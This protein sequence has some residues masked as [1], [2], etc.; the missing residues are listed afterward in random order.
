MT[1][2]RSAPLRLA[3]SPGRLRLA[4]ACALA[5]HWGAL[6][7]L[8]ALLVVGLTILDDYGA[9]FD[10]MRQRE[11]ATMNL[12][13]V[14]GDFDALPYGS[15]RFYGVAFELPLLFVERAF[16]LESDRRAVYILRHLIIHLFFLTGGLFAYFLARRLF[17]GEILAL[18]AM[19]IFLLHPRL[20]A[21]AFFNSKDIPFLALFMIALFLA[22]RAFKRDS[23]AAFVLLGAAVGALMNL[24]IMG[25][26]LLA[27]APAMRALDFAFASNGA[28]RKRV[29]LSTGSFTLAAALATSVSLPYSWSDPVGW[30]ADWW[31]TSSDHPSRPVGLFKGEFYSSVDFPA[32]Y[33]P[34]WFA[35]TAPLFALPLGLAGSAAVVV[36]G[37][38]ARRRAFRNT[39]LRFWALTFGCFALPALAVVLLDANLTTEWRQVYFLWAPFSL[40]AA[41]GLGWLASLLKRAR[42]RAAAYGAA[43]AGLAATLISMALLH[44]NQQVF[45]NALVDRAAPERLRTQYMMDYW[46]HPTRQALE[47][48]LNEHPSSDLDANAP[49]SVAEHLLRANTRILQD[50]SRERLSW[51]PRLDAFTIRTGVGER[52][53][54]AIHRLKVYG[55]TILTIERK[56]DLRAAY[57]A[58][59]A[60]EPLI[61][62]DFDIH[63]LGDALVFVKEPC[64]ENDAVDSRFRIW[65]VPD[66]ESDLPGSWA[67]FGYEDRSFRFPGYGAVFDGKCVASVPLPSYP[68]G[69]VRIEQWAPVGRTTSNATLW[70]ST[71][72]LNPDAWRA[73]WRSAVS[74]EP[75]ARAA[76]DLYLD[77]D[78]LVY[79]KQPCSPADTETRFFLHVAP[80]RADDLPRGR[81]GH[82]FDN[83]GFEF[84]LRG[85]HFDG[86][87][88]A[89][90]TLPD[91]PIESIRTGQYLSGVGD[92]WS[93]EFPIGE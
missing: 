46:G 43:G 57:A 77:G 2:T 88:L 54:L 49:D 24:R 73:R 9:S 76:F 48:L 23:V 8:A 71:V 6:L 65:I 19:L 17:G 28:E 68:V 50:A 63:R 91:Y 15:D 64:S 72:A 40:L 21:H 1:P 53:D 61:R 13:Y 12:E 26:V 70:E 27:A 22:H 47:R 37:A 41:Y 39:R 84:F 85:G 11:I 58:S 82:G 52:S 3:S 78:A 86:K 67:R 69:A 74:G 14:G 33:L 51:T 66:D 36:N 62:A 56:A 31:A 20:H 93:A 55:N 16:G 81:R 34:V 92:V 59:K 45:F 79:A 42:L 83:L 29:L 5:P 90:V 25:V 60:S 4:A 75:L 35:I 87:C 32:E 30:A 44:P 80:E 10:E 89:R 7:A 18:L 38:R